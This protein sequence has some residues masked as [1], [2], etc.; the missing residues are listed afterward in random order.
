[1]VTGMDIIR[2]GQVQC[3]SMTMNLSDAM[4]AARDALRVQVLDLLTDGAPATDEDIDD[5]DELVGMV[6]DTLGVRITAVEDDGTF[7]A[8]LSLPQ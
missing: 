2:C 5:A 1:M 4:L 6:F 8:S 3:K 7:I